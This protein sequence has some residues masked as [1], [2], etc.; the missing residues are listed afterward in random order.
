[1]CANGQEPAVEGALDASPASQH[2]LLLNLRA[3]GAAQ[4]VRAI[5]EQ[6]LDQIDGKLTGLHIDCFHPAAPKPERR[7]ARREASATP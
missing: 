4:Q 1:M 6:E 7:M 5:V 2:E 3:V